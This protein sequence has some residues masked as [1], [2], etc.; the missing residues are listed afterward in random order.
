[1]SRTTDGDRFA[2]GH[3]ATACAE[4]TAPR[5]RPIILSI[6]RARL[7]DLKSRYDPDN[8][9]RRNQNIPPAGLQRLY[10]S[11]GTRTRDLRRDRPVRRDGLRP[12]TTR[13]Y[14]LQQG[15]RHGANRF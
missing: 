7:Q 6:V 15:F 13:N 4:S 9:L 1:V 5:Q 10:G 3:A 2:V 14:R 11:D 8:V 12:A